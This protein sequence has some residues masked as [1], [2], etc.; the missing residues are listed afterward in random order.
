MLKLAVKR[1]LS[2]IVI[3]TFPKACK[4]KDL[5]CLKSQFYNHKIRDCIVQFFNF[6]SSS[7]LLSV[8]KELNVIQT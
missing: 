4:I 7:I 8:V 6:N 1:K 2:I 3:N 5:V